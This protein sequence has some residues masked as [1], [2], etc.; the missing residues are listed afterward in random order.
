MRRKTFRPTEFGK[1]YTQ[2]MLHSTEITAREKNADFFVTLGNGLFHKGDIE[3]A[4][5]AYHQAV[6]LNPMFIDAY[7]F[8]SEAFFLYGYVDAAIGDLRKT[9]NLDPENLKAKELLEKALAALRKRTREL[10]ALKRVCACEILRYLGSG[11]EGTV[12]VARNAKNEKCILKAFYPHFVEQINQ[13]TP[14]RIMRKPVRSSHADLIRLSQASK[15]YSD[16]LYAIDL[17]EN[18]G[19]IQGIM[20]KYENLMQIRRRYLR[21]PDILLGILGAF[22]RAQA[23]LLRDFQLCL[24]DVS[25]RQFMITRT[26]RIRFIDYGVSII[27]IDDFRCMKDHWQTLVFVKL[28]YQLFNPEKFHLFRPANF[29]V[30]FDRSGGLVSVTES[31][32]FLYEFLDLIEKRDFDSFLNYTLYEKAA[33]ELPKKLS[34]VSLCGI[35]SFDL[36]SMLKAKVKSVV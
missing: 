4:I 15:R 29:E 21:H 31:L 33:E 3:G 2:A 26:G 17:L 12:Y 34:M 20:Y 30:I 27:P 22:F 28:L 11:H 36:M 10:I 9:I 25:V 14:V 35:L 8:R 6:Y 7:M 19:K 5:G 13:L 18:D 24:S 32:G 23:C 16:S 1:V